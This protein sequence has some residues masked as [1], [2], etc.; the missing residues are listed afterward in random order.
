MNTP[1]W[2]LSGFG[3]ENACDKLHGGTIFQ[4]TAMGIVWVACQVS[5]GA[6]ETIMAKMHFEEWL[7][8]TVAAEIS[9]LHSDS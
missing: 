6:G 8:E 3:S 9:H 7:W 1:G 5:S 4:D 2:L